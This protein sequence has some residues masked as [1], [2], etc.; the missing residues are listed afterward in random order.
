MK[1]V[2]TTEK[3]TRTFKTMQAR[4]NYIK[5]NHPLMVI[6]NVCDA[7]LPLISAECGKAKK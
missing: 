4:A 7:S 5:K 2:L 1:Y 6:A 3:G